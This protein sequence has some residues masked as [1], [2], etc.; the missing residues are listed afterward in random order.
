MDTVMVTL[1]AEPELTAAVTQ[2]AII[3]FQTYTTPISMVS[4]CKPSVL[5]S[6]ISDY[7]RT[8]AYALVDHFSLKLSLRSS[9]YLELLF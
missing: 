4:L 9:Y 6:L 2:R 1:S 3:H 5:L 8:A 7:P